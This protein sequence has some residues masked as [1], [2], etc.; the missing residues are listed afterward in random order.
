VGGTGLYLRSLTEGIADIPEIPDSFRQ[1]VRTRREEVG[2]EK[3]H[4][5]LKK[6]D[7]A[8]GAKL[9]PGDTQRVLRA[10]EIISFTGKS[11]IEW[12]AMKGEK[13]PYRFFKIVLLPPRD[14]IYQA[15]QDR[16][17]RMIQQGALAEA[18]EVEK[19]KLPDTLASTKALG[20]PSLRAHLRGEMELA[21]AIAQGKLETRQYAKRQYTW[22]KGHIKPDF[23]INKAFEPQKDQEILAKAVEKFKSYSS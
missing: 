7:P 17:E 10:Y 15:C 23:L 8:S 18:G 19:L 3:F 13:P 14:E 16:F 11:Q 22:F 4:D 12:Q 21:A 20:I 6:L 2:P 5:E 9:S 1:N